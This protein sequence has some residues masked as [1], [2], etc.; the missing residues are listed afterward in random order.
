MSL[1][2][3]VGDVFG[4]LA[5][6]AAE[7]TLTRYTPGVYVPATGTNAT[8][9]TT[10]CSCLT[11]MDGEAPLGFKFGYGLVQEGDL[12]ALIPAKGLTFNPLP[13][14]TLT[15]LAATFT[16]VSVHV[17]YAGSVPVLFSCLVRR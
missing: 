12:M 5:D 9:T 2:D 16:I 13:L 17:V 14:D 11:V 4:D 8:G 6:L 10:T 1:L 7:A 3:E 15:V